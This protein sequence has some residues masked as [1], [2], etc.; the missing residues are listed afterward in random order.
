MNRRI[1][2][3]ALGMILVFSVTACKSSNTG[4]ETTTPMPTL[5][6]H[7]YKYINYQK[8]LSVERTDGKGDV[9]ITEEQPD[10]VREVCDAV[11]DAISRDFASKAQ[12]NE[13][14][15]ADPVGV[16]LVFEDITVNVFPLI[17][18]GK[19]ST[20]KIMMEFVTEESSGFY[21][22][23]SEFSAEFFSEKSLNKFFNVK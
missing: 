15:K 17:K 3:I 1:L 7:K 10:L 20:S 6:A 19:P 13:L 14:L 23:D 12:I 4:V 2:A 11:E 5:S 16:K 21:T 9:F 8:C 18:G 22:L